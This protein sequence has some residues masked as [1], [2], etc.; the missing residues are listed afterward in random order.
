[1]SSDRMLRARIAACEKW[2][3]TDPVAGTA[4]A[5]RAGPGQ[6]PYWLDKV[7]PTGSLPL[8]ERTRRA[9]LAKRAYFQRLAL[10]SAQARRRAS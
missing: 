3:Q 5:R 4:A 6:L 2:A 1:M 7:D 9:E 8:A 10:K